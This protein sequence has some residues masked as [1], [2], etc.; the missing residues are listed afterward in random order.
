MSL[1]HHSECNNPTNA[2]AIH[3]I[4][5]RSEVNIRVITFNSDK[6]MRVWVIV[7]V[8]K[9]TAP[10]DGIKYFYKAMFST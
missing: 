7:S 5:E 1:V 3:A 2:V 6:C 9:T 4:E 8:E 10:V